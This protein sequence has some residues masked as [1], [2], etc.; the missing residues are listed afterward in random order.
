MAA[1]DTFTP[2]KATSKAIQANT[3]R[4]RSVSLP[5]PSG[6]P[7]SATRSLLISRKRCL[8]STQPTTIISKAATKPKGKREDQLSWGSSRVRIATATLVGATNGT[9]ANPRKALISTLLSH[10]SLA[11][12]SIPLSFRLSASVPHRRLII[13]KLSTEAIP[14]LT[15]A[16]FGYKRDT[17]PPSS[18]S[19]IRLRTSKR[20]TRHCIIP[21]LPKNAE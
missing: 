19:W 17:R 10:C 16:Y 9:R 3:T 18:T 8:S 11:A 7:S 15:A 21:R 5:V 6:Q 14:Q 2:A 4:T 20:R 1:T 13:P 12:P